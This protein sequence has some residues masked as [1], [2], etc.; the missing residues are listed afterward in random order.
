[1]DYFKLQDDIYLLGAKLQSGD[2]DEETYKDTLESLKIPIDDKFDLYTSTIK[3]NEKDVEF[4]KESKMAIDK[5][6]K[7]RK[8][9]NDYLKSLL[10]SLLYNLGET[11]HKTERS[12]VFY[13]KLQSVNL[14]DEKVI[15]EKYKELVPKINKEALK[16]ALKNGEKING[17]SLVIK[18][19]L[20][21]RM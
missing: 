15:D 7:A 21:I 14:E 4:L 6:I 11:K 2:I 19:S 13:R 5:R 10:D 20:S 8:K 1:M 17:A 16:K 18:N 9:T 12:T 3:R